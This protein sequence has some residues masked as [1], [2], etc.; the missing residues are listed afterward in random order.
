[1][2]TAGTGT[3]TTGGT[4]TSTFEPRIIQFG[5]KILY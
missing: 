1:V 3:P 5:V 4:I 2:P